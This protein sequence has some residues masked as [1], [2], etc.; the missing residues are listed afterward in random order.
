MKSKKNKQKSPTNHGTHSSLA[1]TAIVACGCRAN[2]LVQILEARRLGQGRQA[3]I[4]KVLV[5]KEHALNTFAMPTRVRY[6][7]LRTKPSSNAITIRKNQR[8]DSVQCRE[9]KARD[10]AYLAGCHRKYRPLMPS[11]SELSSCKSLDQVELPGNTTPCDEYRT[12]ISMHIHMKCFQRSSFQFSFVW[13]NTH[14][15]VCTVYLTTIIA[16]VHNQ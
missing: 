16:V 11:E 4:Q 5:A 8:C 2:Q 13:T 10:R 7:S 1:G 12:G 6:G 3:R 9:P 15:C 14:F